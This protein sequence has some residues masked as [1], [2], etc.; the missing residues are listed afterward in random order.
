MERKIAG[1]HQ[2]T[3]GHWVA[4]LE[5]GHTQ[6]VRHAPPWQERP[7][8]LSEAGREAKRG[9]PLDCQFC[10][11]G[12]V[13]QGYEK[14]SGTREFTDQDVPQ[15][16]LNDHRTKPGVW[17]H[18]VVEEGRLEYHCPHGVFV[19]RPGVLGVIEPDTP[20]HLRIIEPVRFRVDFLRADA[21][22]EPS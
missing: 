21:A 8:V 10:N 4:E 2:D 22:A 3:E 17:G 12:S 1:Y 6:H 11:M 13:P 20:H 14:Y 15:A 16:L 19:L 9:E 18:I 5:C 7:W